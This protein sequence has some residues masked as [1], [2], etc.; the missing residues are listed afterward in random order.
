[1]FSTYEGYRPSPHHG[2]EFGDLD[3]KVEFEKK[4]YQFV[5]IVKS[6]CNLTHASP[7]GRE[8]IQQIISASQDRRIEIIGAV[9]PTR[10]D[11]QFEKD[12]DYIAKCTH[13]KIVILDDVFMM[14]Q[15]KYYDIRHN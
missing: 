10:F 1:M 5:G 12:L 13:S 2:H 3:F 11:T 9:C 15:F 14:K 8:M 7:Q 4:K 6:S